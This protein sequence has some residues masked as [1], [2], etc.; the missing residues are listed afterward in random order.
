[1]TL[2]QQ[3]VPATEDRVARSLALRTE[4]TGADSFTASPAQV[5][6]G[7]EALYAVNADGG[8]FRQITHCRGQC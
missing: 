6:N 4:T 7:D 5:D 2:S 8:G 1:M 3:L